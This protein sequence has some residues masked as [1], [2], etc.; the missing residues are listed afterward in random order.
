M[1]PGLLKKAFP[2]LRNRSDEP[3]EANGALA[4]RGE[5]VLLREKALRDAVEDYAWRTDEE[6]SR[7][8]ATQPISM[9]YA[10]FLRYTK[11]E[12]M[13]ASQSSRRFAIDTVEGKHIGNCMYYDISLK[14]GEVELG[15]M[16]GDRDYQGRGYGTEAVDLLLDYI[17]TTTPLN[18]VYLHTLEWNHRAR[19]SFAKSGFKEIQA[20]HRSGFDFIKMEIFRWEWEKL[21]DGQAGQGSSSAQNGAPAGPKVGT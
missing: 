17:F 1:R 18:R 6:I 4:I 2:W 5:R 8:D 19:R 7:L 3:G 16:I 13:Y 12:M 14:R 21:R 11:E 20:V 9:S 10:A 15:I